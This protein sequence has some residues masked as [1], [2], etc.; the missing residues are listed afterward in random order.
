MS[1]GAGIIPQSDAFS[2]QFAHLPMRIGQILIS[3][4]AAGEFDLRHREEAEHPNLTTHRDADAAAEIARFDDVGKYRPLRTAPNLA[5]GWCLIL[6]AE[7]EVRLALDYFY[8]GRVAAFLA[9]A[10]GEL[11]ATPLR[12]TLERQT[13]MYRVA[14]RITLPQ[15]DAMVARVCR[16]ADGC[17]RTIWWKH[18][19]AGAPASHLLPPEKFD[20]AQDQ[21]GRGENC[22][23]LLCQE[24]CNLLVAEARTVV[25]AETG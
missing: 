6:G 1:E 4:T 16:S 21:T 8:P 9:Y 12:E 19:A 2:E 24:A 25:K 13:G 11:K 18:D 15:A 23:P 5:H 20:P 17:L 14:A 7:E 3:R 10:E 22:V